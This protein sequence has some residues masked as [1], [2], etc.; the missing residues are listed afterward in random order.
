MLL[1]AALNGRR[2]REEH[3]AVPLTPSDLQ[4]DAI[5]C[6]DAG[7]HGF[8][9]HPR[10][11]DGVERLDPRWV[12]AAANAVHDVSRWPVSVSTGLW[13]EGEQRRRVA[14]LSRWTGPDA[15]SVNLA[16][17]ESID[18][19]R[20]LLGR[21]IRVE[22]GVWSAEDADLLLRSGLADRVERVL[23]ELIEVAPA[24]VV[25]LADEIH[26]MLDRADVLAPRLQHGEDGTAW[27]A[28]DDAVRRGLD[29]RIGLEDVLVLPD[30]STAQDNAALVAAA[31]GL[32]AGRD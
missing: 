2:T 8:H 21:G 14:M 26:G 17:D 9:V 22:A 18:T 6:G 31:R 28:L 15:A 19:M 20:T 5:A 13:I 23:V 30:G 16:D 29:T 3:R 10:D 24:D 4:G 12:D 11:D 1:Q 27:I 25:T 32:G 7:A